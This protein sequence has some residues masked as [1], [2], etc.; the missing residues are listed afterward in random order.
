VRVIIWSSIVQDRSHLAMWYFQILLCCPGWKD[1]IARL[2]NKICYLI[3][4][5]QKIKA[6]IPCS[7]GAGRRGSIPAISD[8]ENVP[9]F[10]RW[11]FEMKLSPF[12]NMNFPISG[13]IVVPLHTQAR[14]FTSKNGYLWDVLPIFFLSVRYFDVLWF[15]QTNRNYHNLLSDWWRSSGRP[16]SRPFAPES[17]LNTIQLLSLK[18]LYPLYPVYKTV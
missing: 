3:P 13:C 10:R 12:A 14:L 9:S 2:N 8:A 18:K 6:G 7:S 1:R 16:G 11:R 15:Y 5:S 17:I 4:R